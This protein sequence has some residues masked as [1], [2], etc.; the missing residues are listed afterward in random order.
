MEV[1]RFSI[2]CWA[3][4]MALAALSLG[5]EL[6]KP[7]EV[8]ADYRRELEH[9]DAALTSRIAEERRRYGMG[10]VALE[11]RAAAERDLTP[12]LWA[13][14]YRRLAE[15]LGDNWP[16]LFHEKLNPPEPFESINT[17]TRTRL[18]QLR[19]KALESLA[20]EQMRA[21]ERMKD[22]ERNLVRKNR[23]DEAVAAEKAGGNLEK[24]KTHEG[25]EKRLHGFTA[26]QAA[27]RGRGRRSQ[28]EDPEA[29]TPPPDAE[30]PFV[31]D[32]P[33][34]QAFLASVRAES[35]GFHAGPS[36]V[37]L[38]GDAIRVDGG[39]GLSM[40]A[41]VEGEVRIRDTYDTYAD[42]DESLR[43]IQ[44]IK[45]LP[46]GAFVVLAARDDATRRFTG[47][48]R[49]ALLRLGARRGLY[50]LPY[51]SSYLLIGIKGLPPG[52]ALERF[53]MEKVRHVPEQRE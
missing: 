39:R 18:R 22:L 13:A 10:M 16:A 12:W 40:V 42:H 11:K 9:L 49:S 36:A 52:Q 35:G 25:L 51:R 6:P 24:D 21:L 30:F 43:L 1:R 14:R 37:I 26:K 46:Y 15:E 33:A 32:N 3:A 19:E 34:F 44:D 8:A 29:P 45:E 17:E 31:N 28:P 20:S 2:R 23:I 48:A 5:A 53:G 7:G 27:K 50:G 4:A 47:S 38:L 41:V